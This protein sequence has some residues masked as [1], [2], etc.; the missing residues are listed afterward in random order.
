MHVFR[1]ARKKFIHD[2]SGA[3]ARLHG[4]R[5]NRKGTAMLYTAESRSLAIVEYLVH[6]PIALVPDDVC[7]ARITVPEG[8]EADELKA[9]RLPVGWKSYPAS[10]EL[11]ELGSA[12]A[13]E[14]KKLLLKVPSAVVTGEYNILI[15]PAHKLFTRV[16]VLDVEPFEAI[17]RMYGKKNRPP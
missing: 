9:G 5:W 17:K 16:K 14:N 10:E 12:W 2:L 8:T 6:V 7:I 13:K 15:N 11:A 4:G 3:G 1:I